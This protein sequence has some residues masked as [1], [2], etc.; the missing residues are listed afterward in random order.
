[1]GNLTKGVTVGKTTNVL[2]KQVSFVFAIGVALS[3]YSC[4]E[5]A[6][7]RPGETAPAAIPSFSLAWSEYP[8]WSTF[9][10]AHTFGLIDGRKGQL[11]PIEKKWGIDIELREADY[12]SCILLYGSGKVDSACLTNMDVLN[13]CLSRPSVAILPTSTSYGADALIVPNTIQEIKQLRGKSIYGLKRSVSEYFF[14]RVLENL[15]ENEK[16]YTF[17]N[18]DPAAAAT[19]YQQ[20]NPKF[21]AI[22]VWHPFVLETLNKRTDSKRLFDST[23]IPG[24][25]I[26]M[27]QVSQDSLDKPGG[28]AFAC[29]VIETYYAVNERL[30]DPK[31]HNDTVVAL[32][33]KFARL[34]LKSMEQ[35]LRDC[36][37]FATPEAGLA[38]LRGDPVQLPTVGGKLEPITKEG[39]KDV[40]AR[41]IKTCASHEIVPKAPTV[42]Y[43]TKQSAPGVSLRLD[44]TYIQDYLAS[45]ASAAPP[46]GG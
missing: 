32:G 35:V 14:L 45:K 19:A 6:P 29:A 2:L 26:D 40:M 20:S 33:E 17:V 18:M 37:F 10:V 16:D 12:D 41:V 46:G 7:S 22:V 25:I 30:A 1:V 8:S 15:G 21:E 5:K 13:P 36:R 44:P 23:K 39:F 38:L 9:G 28:R 4:K 42:G 31:T 24:E 34:D 27:V 11:G 3:L 43:G